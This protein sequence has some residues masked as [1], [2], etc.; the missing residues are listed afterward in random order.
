METKTDQILFIAET[1]AK[2][3]GISVLRMCETTKVVE[4][5]RVRQIAHYFCVKLINAPTHLVGKL[6]GEKDHATVLHSKKTIN[7]LIATEPKFHNE[8]L[9][10]ESILEPVFSTDRVYNNLRYKQALSLRRNRAAQKRN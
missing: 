1:V 9:L 4:I 6:I 5:V 2:Y 10:M 8:I 7:N 3:H